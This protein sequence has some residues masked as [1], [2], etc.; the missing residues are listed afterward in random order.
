MNNRVILHIDLNC[1]YASVEMV[2]NPA[3]KGRAVAVCGSREDRHGIVLAKSELAKAAGVKT[4][5]IT[6]EA[7]RLCPG[8]IVVPP[9]FQM[10]HKFSKLAKEIYLR[11]SDRVEPYGLDENWVDVTHIARDF[12]EAFTLAEEIRTTV[13]QELGLTV[14][15]GVSFNKIFAK[16]ASDM[17]KP[18]ATTVISPDNF[19]TVAWNAPVGDLLFVGRSSLKTLERFAI[20]TIGDLARADKRMLERHLGKNGG[21]LWEFANGL[22][23]SEVKLVGDVPVPKSIGH[24]ITCNADVTDNEEVARIFLELSQDIARQLRR[25]KLWADGLQIAVKDKALITK[26]FD[27]FLPA[28]TQS[29]R[30]LADTAYSLFLS[31]YKKERP[32]RAL[33]VRATRLTNDPNGSQMDLF[34]DYARLEKETE[35]ERATDDIVAAYGTGAIFPAAILLNDKT[36]SHMEGM[37]VLPK[38]FFHSGGET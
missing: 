34:Y 26:Q 33:T 5:M 15:V 13:S 8:L 31:A 11:Y 14:S 36:R 29:A 23:T 7:E 38:P 19:R 16:L 1:F 10:Y 3:L 12:Q 27:G 20:H 30:L 6:S 32:I 17:K 2:L 25:E 35:L 4:G 9:N 24:G 18:D 21:M 28:R 37:S 22:D